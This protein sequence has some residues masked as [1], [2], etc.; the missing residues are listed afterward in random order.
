MFRCIHNK[1]KQN[2]STFTETDGRVHYTLDWDTGTGARGATIN[3]TID[4]H[5]GGGRENATGE[6][7][8]SVV[9]V[10]WTRRANWQL[11]GT[12]KLGGRGV[13]AWQVW[14]R[15]AGCSRLKK[16]TRKTRM[17]EMSNKFTFTP[18]L[19]NWTFVSCWWLFVNNVE[20]ITALLVWFS[21]KLDDN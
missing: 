13:G 17:L 7:L 14:G 8:C 3:M 19:S 9:L 15:A 11:V 20:K 1:N 18:R 4:S 16:R 2:R 21:K 12:S 5:K 6:A 10:T